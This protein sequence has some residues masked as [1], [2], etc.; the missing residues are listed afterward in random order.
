MSF[1]SAEFGIFLTLGLVLFYLSPAPWRPRVLLGLSYAF[2]ASWSLPGTV[3]L[4]S[5]TTGVYLAARSIEGHSAE[6]AKFA[7]ATITV[8]ALLLVLF[9]FKFGRVLAHIFRAWSASMT[10]AI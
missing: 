10:P 7:L 1:L 9:V 8:A 6:R 3:L 5:V 2:Y 4:L